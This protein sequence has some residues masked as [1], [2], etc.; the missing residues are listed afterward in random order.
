MKTLGSPLNIDANTKQVTNITMVS[1]YAFDNANTT[2]SKVYQEAPISD[3]V[4]KILDEL[5]VPKD[6]RDIEKTSTLGKF[7]RKFRT[8]QN[9]SI[10]YTKFCNKSMDTCRCSYSKLLF[11]AWKISQNSQHPTCY[12]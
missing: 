11:P 4:E 6:K 9:C 8:L 5:N 2:V 1:K 10:S 12:N 7:Y 3:V